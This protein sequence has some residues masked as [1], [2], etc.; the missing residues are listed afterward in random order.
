MIPP[1][2][3]DGMPA[4][5]TVFLPR[6]YD[7]RCHDLPVSVHGR[8]T[9]VPAFSTWTP[10]TDKRKSAAW[11]GGVPGMTRPFSEAHAESSHKFCQ[12]PCC[13]DIKVIRH[14]TWRGAAWLQSCSFTLFLG[15]L[16]PLRLC[17]VARGCR[18]RDLVAGS[19]LNESVLQ[20]RP[21]VPEE[22]Q[23]D[24]PEDDSQD[25][26]TDPTTTGIGNGDENGLHV[27]S[28]P[29]GRCARL[30]QSDRLIMS[31]RTPGGTLALVRWLGGHVA[32][33]RESRDG[34]AGQTVTRYPVRLALGLCAVLMTLTTLVAGG[35][36][37]AAMS[38][39]HKRCR[40]GSS[41]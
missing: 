41:R 18:A 12:T 28:I 17:S 20:P 14:G 29:E 34:Q 27:N 36:A 8:A 25:Y 2:G 7:P 19:P 32:F 3:V 23:S 35:E 22:E 39:A 21:H 1:D 33:G 9:S 40:Q 24:E 11:R 5:S 6:T 31:G 16:V 26:P 38:A 10:S 15:P 4:R 13:S 30:G 37:S